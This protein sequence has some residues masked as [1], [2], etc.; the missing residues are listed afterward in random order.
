VKYDCKK[1]KKAVL[2]TTKKIKKNK[3]AKLKSPKKRQHRT[4]HPRTGSRKSPHTKA[5][6]GCPSGVHPFCTMK[7]KIPFFD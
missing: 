7:K 5:Q 4:P 2:T 3:K 6:R 1:N